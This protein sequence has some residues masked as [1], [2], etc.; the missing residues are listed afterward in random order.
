MNQ[1]SL[2][3]PIRMDDSR[4]KADLR[5]LGQATKATTDGM[6]AGFHGVSG[7]VK[8]T[9]DS[10]G[11]L[12]KAQIGMSVVKATANAI[13]SQY[14]EAS[15][16]IEAMAKSFQKLRSDMNSVASLSGQTS[17]NKFTL[18]MIDSAQKAN[19]TPQEYKSFQNSF[20]SKASLYVGSGEQSKMSQE[21]ADKF[22]QSMAEYAKAKGIDQADM[23]GFAG[24]LLAQQKG[25]TNAA[26]MLSQAGKVFGTLEASSADVSHLLPMMTRLQAQGLR[27]E[28][29]APLL[30]Q[31]PE[32]GPEEEG[33]YLQRAMGAVRDLNLK[34][35][36]ADYG[37]KK[38]DSQYDQLR[39]L[40]SNL[41]ERQGRGEDMDAVLQKIAP[42]DVAQRALRGLV[43]QGK[44]GLD[45]W[46][47]LIDQTAGDVV[48][49][50]IEAYR[51]TET[52]AQDRVDAAQAAAHARIG[53]RNDSVTRRRQIADVEASEGGLVENKGFGERAAVA[54]NP[55]GDDID[56]QA[57]NRQMLR[58]A[59]AE[60]GEGMGVKDYAASTS[61][62]ATDEVMRTLVQ[63]IEE[64]N[65]L[66]KRQNDLMEADAKARGQQWV[67]PLSAPPPRIDGRM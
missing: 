33:T 17:G 52:G 31:A 2:V 63:R 26:D 41:Q 34:G 24:G 42:E 66:V 11:G 14:S 29:A 37:V 32:Y 9:S 5:N 61:R 38:T 36:G 4:A 16:K 10:I 18:G 60:L 20:L 64:Q 47:G 13:V 30:A 40:V 58:R 21:D 53:F 57:V 12:I 50:A 49:K 15:Q 43:G 27:A 55:F 56:T 48:D 7:A 1:E 65:A 19:V 8:G 54:L 3:I 45:R 67:V 22:S 59:H 62:G 44:E 35:T 46:K 6:Q 28:E 39:G 25:K 23:A 51:G